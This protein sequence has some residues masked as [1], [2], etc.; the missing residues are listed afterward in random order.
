MK[1]RRIVLSLEV[2][3]DAP[4]SKLRS[5]A[6]YELY[7]HHERAMGGQIYTCSVMQAQANVVEPLDKKGGKK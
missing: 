1:T 2:E 7:V 5:G 3:T 4:L 6:C